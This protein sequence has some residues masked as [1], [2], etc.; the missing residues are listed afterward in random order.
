MSASLSKAQEREL[1]AGGDSAVKTWRDYFFKGGSDT[2]ALI[3]QISLPKQASTSSAALHS[4]SLPTPTPD[5]D[6]PFPPRPSLSTIQC[7]FVR[8]QLRVSPLLFLVS[9]HII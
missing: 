1:S 3:L 5:Q 7:W 8:L 4:P 9:S 6:T 2:D